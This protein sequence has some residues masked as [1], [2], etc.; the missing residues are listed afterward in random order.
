M[1]HPSHVQGSKAIETPGSF[2]VRTSPL[3]IRPV[4]TGF[5]I[6]ETYEHEVPESYSESQRI[7]PYVR[8]IR[9]QAGTG[10]APNMLNRLFGRGLL[11]IARMHPF[12]RGT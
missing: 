10:G 3:H 2:E 6:T 1:P 8:N 5:I 7:D 4:Q 11:P 12:Y 9:D